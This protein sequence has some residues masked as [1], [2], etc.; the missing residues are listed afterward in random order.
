MITGGDGM[1][2][3]GTPYVITGGA[4]AGFKICERNAE[5]MGVGDHDEPN[6]AQRH[7]SRRAFKQINDKMERVVHL[8]RTKRGRWSKVVSG[9]KYIVVSDGDEE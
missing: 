2:G 1:F 8:Q 3:G 4:I 5:E 7:K 9:R 6:P